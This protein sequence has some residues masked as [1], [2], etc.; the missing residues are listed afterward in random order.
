[1]L[2]LLAPA[3]TV[4][5]SAATGAAVKDTELLEPSKFAPWATRL[6]VAPGFRARLRNVNCAV[7]PAPLLA[8]M[9]ELPAPSVRAPSDC[10]EAAP[11]LPRKLRVPPFKPIG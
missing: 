2:L 10:A 8:V 1:M 5:C 9:V 7:A 6:R 3:V 4:L 11:A